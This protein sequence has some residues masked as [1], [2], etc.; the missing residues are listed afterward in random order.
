MNAKSVRTTAIVVAVVSFLCILGGA[1][2]LLTAPTPDVTQVPDTHQA[3]TNYEIP[4]LIDDAISSAVDTIYGAPA[5]VDDVAPSDEAVPPTQTEWSGRLEDCPQNTIEFVRGRLL[6][7]E[8]CDVVGDC[9]YNC[10]Q[11]VETAEII[12]TMKPT[13][14]A[15]QVNLT[16]LPCPQFVK[17]YI[18]AFQGLNGF[19]DVVRPGA[20]C[21]YV[22]K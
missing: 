5:L 16:T 22:C 1:Y 19:C 3:D 7:A 15:N 2:L 14:P 13:T 4:S 11:S 9:V 8:T 18:A 20:T 17:D 10:Y 12:A 21:Y 6:Y